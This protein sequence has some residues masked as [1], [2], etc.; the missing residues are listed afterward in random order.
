MNGLVKRL[1]SSLAV[2][3][4]MMARNCGINVVYGARVHTPM[5]NGRTV[6]IPTLDET[7][8]NTPVL[9]NGYIDHEA[10]HLALT[11]FS[12]RPTTGPLQHVLGQVC[13]DLRQESLFRDK[14]PGAAQNIDRLVNVL[15]ERNRF[16]HPTQPQTLADTIV[17]WL[18][19]KG[20]GDFLGQSAASKFAE[21]RE[22]LVDK[23]YPGLKQR[24]WPVFMTVVRAPAT[25][26]AL[27]VA[28][29]LIDEIRAYLAERIEA[30]GEVEN[31]EQSA[32]DSD[33]SLDEVL[34]DEDRPA[35]PGESQESEGDEADSSPSNSDDGQ[36]TNPP[37]EGQPDDPGE[38]QGSE[39]DEAD[40]S[41]SNSDDGQSTNPP[42]EGQPDDPGESQGSEGDGSSGAPSSPGA[43]PNNSNAPTADEADDASDEQLSKCGSRI[44]IQAVRDLL[45]A[46]T[47][48]IAEVDLGDLAAELLPACQ[49]ASQMPVFFAPVNEQSG[50]LQVDTTE[51]VQAASGLASR[52]Q[53]VVQSSKTLPVRRSDHGRKMAKR[54]LVNA[55]MGD[56]KVFLKRSTIQQVNTYVHILVDASSSMGE[57][58]NHGASM[59]HETRMSL[60]TKSALA[61]S[62][63][64]DRVPHLTRAVSIFPSPT[65]SGTSTILEPDSAVSSASWRALPTDHLTPLGEALYSIAPAVSLRPETRKIVL[66]LTDGDPTDPEFVVPMIEMYTNSGIEM[67]GIGI[68][69]DAVGNFFRNHEVITDIAALPKA[70]IDALAKAASHKAAA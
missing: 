15:V 23:V 27:R 49:T 42:D 43:Q 51:S 14:F 57:S 45:D 61:A 28:Q 62:L 50:V 47:D 1:E 44:V 4:A 69:C 34:P 3:C 32:G 9:L 18:L 66:V 12:P 65:G 38:S 19:A 21:E 54:K 67:I 10:G 13:E 25:A 48:D 5:T 60:A 26:D 7:D 37:D 53:R 30:Q 22:P 33:H 24:L 2:V 64:L 59:R 68:G 16:G 6:W 40:S 35:D 52:L 20:R 29:E 36:S 11:D 31:P 17:F 56:P 70:V 55:R 58:V 63:A 8:P 41:P 46:S 39:G